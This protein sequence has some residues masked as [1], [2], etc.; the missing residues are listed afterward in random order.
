MGEL[1]NS[2]LFIPMLILVGAAL[3][4]IVVLVLFSKKKKNKTINNNISLSLDKPISD[5]EQRIETE[6]IIPIVEVNTNTQ[7]IVPTVPMVNDNKEDSILPTVP[8][9][10][11]VKTNEQ[12]NTN[13]ILP[14]VPKVEEEP[15]KEVE[16]KKV[17]VAMG[18]PPTIDIPIPTVDDTPITVQEAKSLVGEDLK[19]SVEVEKYEAVQE[20]VPQEEVIRV[21]EAKPLIEEN[22]ESITV[23]EAKSIV[24]ESGEQVSIEEAKPVTNDIGETAFKSIPNGDVNINTDIHVDP[25]ETV[26][27]KTE[28]FSLEDIQKELNKEEDKREVL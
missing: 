15:I 25:V 17:E 22:Q 3:I 1:V 19:D 13:D 7:S 27:N 4:S 23:E 21:T 14:S 11:E 2:K 9:I 16:V 24:E 26:S 28:I 12:N 10:N 5:V 6:A 18:P 20:E 8:V